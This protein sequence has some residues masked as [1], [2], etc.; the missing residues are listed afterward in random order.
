MGLLVGL[1]L[2]AGVLAV[3]RL[4]YETTFTFGI[5]TLHMQ[6]HWLVLLLSAGS[7]IGALYFAGKAPGRAAAKATVIDTLKQNNVYEL[8][9]KHVA[10][11]KIMSLFLESMVH[12]L[13]KISDAIQ[14]V[15][16][17]LRCPF[18]SCRF[19]TVTIQFFG[20]YALSDINGYESGWHEL[21]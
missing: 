1:G 10:G 19:G 18:F 11:G 12:W 13:L 14:S 16:V 6:I 20:F 2:T 9:K 7:G 8:K 4:L 17:P 5:V 21:Y 3:I 15:F